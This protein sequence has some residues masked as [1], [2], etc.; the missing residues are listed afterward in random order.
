MANSIYSCK[1]LVVYKLFG[2]ERYY[3]SWSEGE[4][5]MVEVVNMV[6]LW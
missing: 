3:S 1:E 5:I 6:V 2:C 4:E